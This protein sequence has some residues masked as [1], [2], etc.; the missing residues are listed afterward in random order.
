MPPRSRNCASTWAEQKTNQTAPHRAATNRAFFTA[1]PCS[2]VQHI[3]IVEDEE[4]LAIPIKYNLEAEGYHVTTVGDGPKALTL[5]HESPETVDLIILDLM[6]PGM[7]G[8]AVCEAI[9][10][11]GSQVPI[12]MLSARTLVED[13]IRGFNVGTDLYLQKPFDLEELMSIVRNLLARQRRT[14]AGPRRPEPT[15]R[16]DLP[17]RPG[18]REFRHLSSDRRRSAPAADQPRNEAAPLLCRTRRLGRH[19]RRTPRTSLGHVAQPHHADRGQ[20]YRQSP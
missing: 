4:H 17:L 19:P 14:A 6:L 20:F 13:R 1:Y 12:L 5:F 10:N 15:R 2:P 18:G 9:R 7:S 11:S 3:L 8:Y 16:P